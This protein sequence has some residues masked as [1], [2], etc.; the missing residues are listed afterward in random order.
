[1]RAITLW[2]PW[3][4]LIALGDKTI[5]TRAHDLFKG[6]KCSR[7]AIHA[8]KQFQPGVLEYASRFRR[9]PREHWSIFHKS[10]C[11]VS[12]IVCTAMVLDARW[13]TEA[14]NEAALCECD[15]SRFGL[16][17]TGVLQVVPPAKC[18]GHQGIWEWSQE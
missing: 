15:E 17:L 14:D 3:A 11:P 1:M 8:G 9:I 7:V 16:I 18:G 10:Q 13:L 5:E 6:L 4:S 2:Q 12:C